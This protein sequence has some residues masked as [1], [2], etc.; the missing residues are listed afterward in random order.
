M[1]TL[2]NTSQTQSYLLHR[3]KVALTSQL[4]AILRLTLPSSLGSQGWIP[5]YRCSVASVTQNALSLSGSGNGLLSQSRLILNPPL[6][7]KY[8]KQQNK[9][10]TKILQTRFQGL[11][12]IRISSANFGR[13]FKAAR[14]LILRLATKSKPL[15]ITRK[16]ISENVF[17]SRLRH[18]ATQSGYVP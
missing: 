9:C 8:G 7:R 4:A 18:L 13:L 14:I 17:Q 3:L 6:P 16:A 10:S 11:T 1:T 5:S 2:R 12:A 15:P